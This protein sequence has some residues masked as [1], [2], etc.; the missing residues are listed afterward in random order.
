M[1]HGASPR[2]EWN[3]NGSTQNTE[4][5]KENGV[6]TTNPRDFKH[7]QK[8]YE[9]G[10][11]TGFFIG[12]N[13]LNMAFPDVP[14]DPDAGPLL[15]VES[16]TK[17]NSHPWHFHKLVHILASYRRFAEHLRQQGFD[18]HLVRARPTSPDFANSARASVWKP[19]P[20][21][22]RGNMPLKRRSWQPQRN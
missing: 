2:L 6:G 8:E 20:R 10:M 15:M 18:V 13:D 3:P 9:N 21:C 14:K 17:G 4:A 11:K 7:R 12:P 16:V 5:E 22:V 1:P 19:S